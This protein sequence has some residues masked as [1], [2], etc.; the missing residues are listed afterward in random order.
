MYGLING[1]LQ[2]MITTSYGEEVW[3]EV[4][5][6]SGVPESSFL[7]MQHYDDAYTYQLAGSA[8]EVLDAPLDTCLEMFGGFWIKEVATRSFAVLMETTGNNTVDFLHNLNGLHDR[9]TSTFLD[10]VPP[11]FRVE[12]VPDSESQY[13]VHYYSKRLGL[14]PFVTGLLKGLAEHFG[15]ELH[16]LDLNTVEKDNNTHAIFKLTFK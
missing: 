8:A 4:L 11:E 10:Y 13:L 14:T 16:I 6:R 15:D 7:A 2:E 12:P 3:A 9:I 1:A 5:E